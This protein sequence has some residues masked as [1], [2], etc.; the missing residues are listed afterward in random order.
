MN[1]FWIPLRECASSCVQIQRGGM[2]CLLL[3]VGCSD[4]VG[5]P[6][7]VDVAQTTL[8]S[9]MEGWKDGKTQKDLLE[10]SPSIFVQ[11]TEWN[12]GTKLLDYEI[13]SDDRP[14]GPNLVA[15][16]KLKISKPDGN[17]AEKT[18]TYVVSTSPSLTVY[19]NTMK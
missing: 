16:V 19:R 11:E 18:A 3:L 10:G 2:I 4:K 5:A 13:I 15:T 14:V 9:A 6:V 7:I 12:D 1:R 8:S 17:V